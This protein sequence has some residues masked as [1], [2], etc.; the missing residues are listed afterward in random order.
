VV[1]RSAGAWCSAFHARHAKHDVF[2]A[3]GFPCAGP[4]YGIVLCGRCARRIE[5]SVPGTKFNFEFWSRCR[6]RRATYPACRAVIATYKSG[7]RETI[8]QGHRKPG[9]RPAVA[10]GYRLCADVSADL[11]NLALNAHILREALSKP[12]TVGFAVAFVSGDP[13]ALAKAVAQLSVP[14]SVPTAELRRVLEALANDLMVEL[15]DVDP[16]PGDGL[17]DLA[18]DPGMVLADQFQLHRARLAGPRLRTA[19]SS[20]VIRSP[21]ESRAAKASFR[22]RASVSGTLAKRIPAKRPPRTAMRLSNQLPWWAERAL[23]R[24]RPIPAGLSP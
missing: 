20:T 17:G 22:A 19:L 5:R 14:R 16:A 7:K 18:D 21:S 24:P 11:W 8:A 23:D 4:R 1:S 12:I 6:P 9:A 3:P 13:E 15:L 10:P 2:L